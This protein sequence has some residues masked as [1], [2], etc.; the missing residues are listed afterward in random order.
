MARK[1]QHRQRREAQEVRAELQHLR[2]E[3]QRLKRETKRLRGYVQKLLAQLNAFGDEEMTAMDVFEPKKVE[4]QEV[5]AECGHTEL[6]RI[7]TPTKV[8]VICPECKHRRTE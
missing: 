2:H 5:C 7:Q 4:K 1:V 3:N 8:L 6:K